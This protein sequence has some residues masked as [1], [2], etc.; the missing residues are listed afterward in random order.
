[1]KMGP[2]NIATDLYLQYINT[3]N[4]KEHRFTKY[5]SNY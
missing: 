5:I 4:R 3:Q 1:M 2:T